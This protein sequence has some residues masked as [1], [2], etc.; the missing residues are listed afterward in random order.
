M[1]SYN[2]VTSFCKYFMG[3][4]EECIGTNTSIILYITSLYS[5]HDIIL[6][7]MFNE[8]KTLC[9]DVNMLLVFA[10]IS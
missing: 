9:S 6:N 2:C 10:M 8:V 4:T 7:M 1:R 5:M 3:C